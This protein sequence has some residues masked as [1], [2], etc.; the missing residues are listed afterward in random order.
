[1]FRKH[2]KIQRSLDEMNFIKINIR[3]TYNKMRYFYYYNEINYFLPNLQKLFNNVYKYNYILFNYFASS[4]F[5]PH[6]I[7]QFHINLIV[8]HYFNLQNHFFYLMYRH[9]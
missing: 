3:V 9:T 6:K 7:N 1:M 8:F 4:L 5:N 2:I